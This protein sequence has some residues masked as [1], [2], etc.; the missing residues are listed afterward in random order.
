M[1]ND[2]IYT[3]S[4]LALQLP[5]EKEESARCGLCSESRGNGEKIP[6][7]SSTFWHRTNN[8]SLS[9]GCVISLHSLPE[10][11]NRSSVS[12]TDVCGCCNNSASLNKEVIRLGVMNID[13]GVKERSDFN[14]WFFCL[15]AGGLR[16]ELCKLPQ[17]P[18]LH[19][20][21]RSSKVKMKILLDLG[22]D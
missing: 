12:S 9:A 17:F 6:Y 19:L 16:G 14:S 7:N 3:G 20:Y 13:L 1:Y 4:H 2:W 22:E 8:C 5:G 15:L 18:F 21:S 11:I 10:S